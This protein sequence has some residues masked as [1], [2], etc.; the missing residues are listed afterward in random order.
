LSRFKDDKR[1]PDQ[2]TVKSS[3]KDAESRKCQGPRLARDHGVNNRAS[4]AGRGRSYGLFLVFFGF[5]LSRNFSHPA[6]PGS[7]WNDGIYKSAK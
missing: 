4:Q 3:D 2:E 1:K 5:S 7:T 6:C